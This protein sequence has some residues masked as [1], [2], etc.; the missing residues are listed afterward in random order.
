MIEVTRSWE[1]G[2]EQ[3]LS[4]S[5]QKE[6]TLL[7]CGFQISRLQNHEII[8]FYHSEAPSLWL[9]QQ[10]QETKL[11]LNEYLNYFGCI[12]GWL[13]SEYNFF[14]SGSSY[15][16]FKMQINSHE[17]YSSSL[18]FLMQRELS[19]QKIYSSSFSN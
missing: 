13:R 18:I 4:P 12:G 14:Y 8:N 6:P 11:A 17:F 5:L 9:L 16:S 15:I 7:T 10:S 3:I 19:Y 1:S 2:L